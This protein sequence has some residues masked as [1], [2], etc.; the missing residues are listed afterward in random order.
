MTKD[1]RE[2]REATAS[3]PKIAIL[4]G[5]PAGL[6]AAFALT[7]QPDWNKR[8]ESVTVYSQG[9]R[10]GGKLASGRNDAEDGRV[11]EH[12]LHIFLGFYR[13][14]L[15]MLEKCYGELGF[16][17][18]DALQEVHHI[19][20]AEKN[21]QD[22]SL[23]IWPLDFEREAPARLLEESDV[24]AR[25][26]LL[27]AGRLVAYARQADEALFAKASIA[28]DHDW[29]DEPPPDNAWSLLPSALREIRSSSQTAV[30]LQYDKIADWVVAYQEKQHRLQE[31]TRDPEE[32]RKQ[33]VIDLIAAIVQGVGKNKLA[34]KTPDYDKMDERDLREWLKDHGASELSTKSAIVEAA[35][36]LTFS[37]D[38]TGLGAGTAVRGL[39]RMLNF[40]DALFFLPRGGTGEVLAAPVYLALKK[41]GV[42][43]QFFSSV[44]DLVVE[45]GSVTEV[46]LRKQVELAGDYDPLLEHVNGEPTWRRY[47]PVEPLYDLV[48]DGDAL[49]PL[50]LDM[51]SPAGWRGW[52]GAHEASL[53]KGEHFDVVILG[54]PPAAMKGGFPK[55][56]GASTA[57]KDAAARLPTTRTQ[58]VQLWVSQSVEDDPRKDDLVEGGSAAE[59][60]GGGRRPDR[61][62]RKRG[63]LATCPMPFDTWA[64]MSVSLRGKG[65]RG[66]KGLVYLCGPA[67][68]VP[69][70]PENNTRKKAETWLSGVLPHVWERGSLAG[71]DLLADVY[72]RLNSHPSDRYVLSQP[73]TV[74]LRP[75]AHDPAIANLYLVGDWTRTELNA[76]CVEAAVQSGE[77]AAR[78][79]QEATQPP[80]PP[81]QLA[82][83]PPL[84]PYIAVDG[85]PVWNG[86]F[87]YRD[88]TLYMFLVECPNPDRLT[89]LCDTYLN[90]VREE[91]ETEEPGKEKPRPPRY[92]PLGNFVAVQ[93][94]RAMEATTIADEYKDRGF[95]SPTALALSIPVLKLDGVTD[96]PLALL[97]FSP[98]LFVDSSMEMATGRETY[99][100]AKLFGS[101]DADWTEIADE[102]ERARTN[103]ALGTISG[104]GLIEVRTAAIPKVMREPGKRPPVA[105]LTVRDERI[106]QVRRTKDVPS[107]R[108][109][110]VLVEDVL[111]QLAGTL[112]DTG[113]RLNRLMVPES[114]LT[115]PFPGMVGLKQFR[116]MD[117]P[118]LACFREVVE[119]KITLSPASKGILLRS[120]F[121]VSFGKNHESIKV[122]EKLGFAEDTDY[123]AA[124]ALRFDFPF[125]QIGTKRRP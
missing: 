106:V 71:Q 63:V 73:G 15:R 11:E 3:K 4:G 119:P 115:E 59:R 103:E 18:A 25:A 80:A 99:G 75:K 27:L 49:K 79:V 17:M 113:L 94:T 107:D 98:Y 69:P 114:F 101:F 57:L 55:L 100:A 97:F 13:R 41:R 2:T 34:D 125:Y 6:A 118:T 21:D 24:D 43:F 50:Q 1:S 85:E 65:E 61:W 12:G 46:K 19:Q 83:R 48:K 88:A 47:W 62:R 112:T 40:K 23:S 51:E 66:A 37:A 39:L 72:A 33:I 93:C 117:D 104:P 70:T 5:G 45:D 109:G 123:G 64:D 8:L 84:P 7:E 22:S 32:R 76:G 124:F 120:S 26:D 78:L 56:L 16:K 20:L 81:G 116:D 29:P 54:I 92:V 111:P 44:E 110:L 58:S 31:V 67:D 60:P 42:S 77:T 89:R 95:M 30:Q 82:H 91:P 36:R 35:Y 108:G 121:T 122:P 102:Q 74:N 68:E 28:Q 105:K 52:K 14:T 10:L 90:F 86:P 96:E 53:K 38:A 87:E 9:F